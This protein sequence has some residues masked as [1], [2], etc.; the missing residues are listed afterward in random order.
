MI[1]SKT[2]KFDKTIP[3]FSVKNRDVFISDN[4]SLIKNYKNIMIEGG[5]EMFKFSKN[6][7]DHH[8]CFISPLFKNGKNFNDLDDEFEILNLQKDEKDIILWMKRSRK[9]G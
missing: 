4:F 1:L 8:L 3:L 5:S 9:N 2:K 7:V 6:I